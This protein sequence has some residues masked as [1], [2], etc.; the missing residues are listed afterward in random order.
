MRE[1]YIYLIRGVLISMIR[2][3]MALYMRDLNFAESGIQVPASYE[4][5][6]INVVALMP[7]EITVCDSHV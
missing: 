2:L 6:I 4:G 1:A 7:P 5:A 3:F